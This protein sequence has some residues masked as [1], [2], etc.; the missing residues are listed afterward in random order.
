[1]SVACLHRLIAS[2]RTAGSG[3]VKEPFLEAPGVHRR[4]NRRGAQPVVL[5]RGAHVADVD[6]RIGERKVDVEARQSLDAAGSVDRLQRAHRIAVGVGRL[7]VDELSEQ[8]QSSPV[9]IVTTVTPVPSLPR[10]VG[11][12]LDNLR[13]VY[14]IIG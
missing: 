10:H 4:C 6:G 1:M 3:F 2:A 14:R 13:G 8:P 12:P 9:L 5:E 7:A 11:A